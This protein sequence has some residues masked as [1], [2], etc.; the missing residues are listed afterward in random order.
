[1]NC[2]LGRFNLLSGSDSIQARE[3][4]IHYHNIWLQFQGG[5][6]PGITIFGLTDN[7]ELGMGAEG[8][9][10]PSCI[11]GSSS[12]IKTLNWRGSEA[13][14]I[15]DESKKSC[16]HPQKVAGEILEKFLIQHI[17]YE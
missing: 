16:S 7:F 2:R 6:D 9:L 11:I 17:P 4:D 10:Q 3:P 14:C 5:L 8:L 13:V 12:T 15:G 1:M